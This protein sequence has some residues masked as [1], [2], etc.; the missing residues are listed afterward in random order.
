MRNS[1]PP[2]NDLCDACLYNACLYNAVIL[3]S[4][5]SQCM[6][7]LALKQKLT[8]PSLVRPSPFNTACICG[9][10]GF[11]FQAKRSIHVRLELIKCNLLQTVQIR[12]FL[13]SNLHCSGNDHPHTKLSHLPQNSYWDLN[14][15][16]HPNL[17]FPSA[18]R[19]LGQC[20]AMP[21]CI[22]LLPQGYLIFISLVME[23]FINFQKYIY[24]LGLKL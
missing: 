4:H 17:T 2:F 21:N 15:H 11:Q 20:Q 12:G 22:V 14:I 24:S 6:F 23:L 19:G 18:N 1:Q 16:S 10:P 13:K 9:R 7:M 8:R 3:A 5:F